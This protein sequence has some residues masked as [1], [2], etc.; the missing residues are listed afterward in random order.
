MEK[1]NGQ[2]SG[3]ITELRPD[4]C[5]LSGIRSY[6]IG[7]DENESGHKYGDRRAYFFPED[8]FYEE[9]DNGEKIYFITIIPLMAKPAHRKR[10]VPIFMCDLSDHH[11]NEIKG[12]ARLKGFTIYRKFFEKPHIAVTYEL[13]EGLL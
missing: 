11:I 4:K 9:D 12:A 3:H 13:R 2:I 6:F 10:A 7:K 5:L 8:V 1:E